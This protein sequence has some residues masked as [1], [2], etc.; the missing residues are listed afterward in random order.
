VARR[1]RITLEPGVIEA[2]PVEENPDLL[3]LID[4]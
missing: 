3:G 1:Q 2:N 4:L